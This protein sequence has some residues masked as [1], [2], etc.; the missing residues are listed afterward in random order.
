MV[1][2]VKFSDFAVAAINDST[3][4]DVGL[5]SGI[6]TRE[7]KFYTWTTAGRPAAPFNGL[8]GLNTSLQ[9][10]EFWD[11]LANTW[12]QLADTNVF[13]ILASH[14]AG[15]GASL[16]GLQDQS[17][18]TSKFV[19]DL[20]NATFIAQTSNGSLQN[21]QFL[22]SLTTG[23]VKNTTV[24]GALSISA[25]LTSIDSLTTLLGDILYVSAPNTYVNLAGNITTT[26]KFLSQTGTGAVSAAPA[27]STVSA[28]D[29]VSPAAL[30]KT[31]DTNVTLTLDG[32]PTVALLAATSLTL[33]WTGTLSATRGGLGLSNPTAHGILVGEGSSAV[34]P[35][36]LSSGQILI[37]STG[38]DPV[39]AAIG[40][41]TGILVGNGAGSISV[42]LAAIA[43]QRILANI[44]GGSTA[45][46]ANTLTAIIDACIGSV[47]GDLLYRNAASWVVLAPGVSGQF[48]Q[49]QGAAANPQ[50]VTSATVTPAALTKTD[51]AN[52]TLTLGGSPTVALLAATSLT[53]GW[54]GQLSVARG[55]T[56]LSSVTAHDLLI[57]NGTNALTLLAPSATSGIALVSQGAAADPAYSTVVVAGGG[58][59]IV[60]T[61]AYGLIAGGTTAT[62]AF[63][64]VGTGTSGYLLQSNGNAALPSYTTTP[65]VQQIS[66]TDYTKGI[67]GTTSNDDAA[68]GYVGYFASSVISSGS[69]VS[70]SDNTAADVTFINLPAGDFDVWGNVAFV[71]NTGTSSYAVGWINSSS[72][73]QPDASL[74]C[75]IHPLTNG[76]DGMCVPSRRFKS[77]AAQTIYLSV[78]AGVSDALKACGGIYARERR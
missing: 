61:T 62:G 25:P 19:Q 42:S 13:A 8:L 5:S 64:N 53:L 27:W 40:S 38:V 32:S 52:V 28:G 12:T 51:D 63:Q 37:G 75:Q 35:I 76:N 55:G 4:Q 14:A 36:V 68:S 65:S 20:A 45:P 7:K 44:S 41:G 23:I 70:L 33:G 66:F 60:T 18:V 26:K 71:S 3:T 74:F 2:T 59:G 31:D 46:T 54:T 72:A 21:A 24:T 29:I 30:T 22:G 69:A 58:T 9:Q 50:W 1:N 57:G 34:T 47:Q 67:L 56:G 17:N 49:T 48:L 73:T 11:S 43:D 6:N 39:A 15:M 77:N 16:I 10:Y 78:V